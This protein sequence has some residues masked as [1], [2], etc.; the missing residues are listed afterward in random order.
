MNDAVPAGSRQQRSVCAPPATIGMRVEDVDTPALI[1]D[2]DAFERNLDTMMAAIASGVAGAPGLPA[3]P[4]V[5]LRPHAKTHKSA[6]IARLQIARGAVGVCCQKVSE[7][8]ALI[9]GGIDDVLVTNEIV[10]ESKVKRLAALARRAHLGVC[11]D[12]I[13]Q[14]D[15]IGVAA[16]GV[17]S[18]IDVY[19]EPDVDQRFLHDLDQCVR[20]GDRAK[21]LV[22]I[23]Q[24]LRATVVRLKPREPQRTMRRDPLREQHHIRG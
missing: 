2:L 16:T 13:A 10:G 24:M 17:G 11:V 1:I 3:V 6:D 5:R 7:A 14:I 19:I 9:D 23:A 4:A 18:T 12:D 15:P 20:M 8:E 21:S 22:G